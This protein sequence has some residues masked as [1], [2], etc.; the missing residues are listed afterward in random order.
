MNI[1]SCRVWHVEGDQARAAGDSV[2]VEEPLEIRIAGDTL[3]FTMRTPGDDHAL[4]LGFLLAEGIIRSIADVGSIAHCGRPGDEGYGNVIDVAPGPG[5]VLDPETIES[6]RRAVA[7]TS[8]CGVCGRKS[9]DDLL[10][11]VGRV[12]EG[13]EFPLARLL[14]LPARLAAH[15]PAFSHTG[16]SHAAAAF[17]AAGEAVAWAEDVGRHNAVDK[18]IGRLLLAGALRPSAAAAAD[19]AAGVAPDRAP[20]VLFVSGRISFEIVQ[21]AAAARIAFVAGVSAPSSLALSLAEHAGVTIAGFV[22]G[23]RANVYTHPWRVGLS[24]IEGAD[25][26]PDPS[27]RT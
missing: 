14:D 5:T 17:D 7:T 13:R 23:G 9:I 19:G 11:R 2:L 6:S 16:G 25:A 12:P 15:Q 10:A 21:K 3:A 27:N 8:A 18:V 26:V 20:A 24:P 22:R 1:R 4:T